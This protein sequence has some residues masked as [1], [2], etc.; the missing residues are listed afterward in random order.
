MQVITVLAEYYVALSSVDA[1]FLGKVDSKDIEFTL[2][3]N[4][5]FLL[6]CLLV[7][8]KELAGQHI[9]PQEL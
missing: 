8:P 5:E 2:V 6:Q 3:K 9:C 4:L 1:G 7:V